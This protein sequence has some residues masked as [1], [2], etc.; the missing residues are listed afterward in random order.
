MD[1]DEALYQEAKS[2]Y[3]YNLKN[4]YKDTDFYI[5]QYHKMIRLEKYEEAKAI[6]EVLADYDIKTSEN[7]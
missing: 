6:T 1:W 3:E 2:S 7:D 5:K 4:R